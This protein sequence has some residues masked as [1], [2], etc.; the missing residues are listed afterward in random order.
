MRVGRSADLVRPFLHARRFNGLA[1]PA[2]CEPRR[3][4]AR[5]IWAFWSTESGLRADLGFLA[6]VPCGLAHAPRVGLLFSG[7]HRR[8]LVNVTAAGPARRSVDNGGGG[9]LDGSSLR[10]PQHMTAD[11]SSPSSASASRIAAG[12][13]PRAPFPGLGLRPRRA[14][15]RRVEERHDPPRDAARARAHRARFSARA[16]GIAEADFYIIRARTPS[17]VKQPYL[18][19]GARGLRAIGAR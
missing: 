18:R 16:V 3:D 12:R 14:P 19:R 9:V 6:V 15:R 2:R 4:R 5:V 7:E 10:C 17:T 1:S 11:I 13:G 8:S